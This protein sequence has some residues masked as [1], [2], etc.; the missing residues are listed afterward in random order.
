M[1]TFNY[2]DVTVEFGV[3]AN[4][5]NGTSI[6]PYIAPVSAWPIVNIIGMCIIAF[7]IL[8]VCFVCILC[9]FVNG[10]QSEK[11]ANA[12]AYSQPLQEDKE[13]D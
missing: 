8:V 4:A 12:I 1:T 13:I 9:K 2:A 6:D 5:P 11:E 3:N 7:M 10:K